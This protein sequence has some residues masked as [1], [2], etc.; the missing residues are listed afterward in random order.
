M[1]I[2]V[3]LLLGRWVADREQARGNEA[4]QVGG[5]RHNLSRLSW[6]VLAAVADLALH[7]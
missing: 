2:E 6:V 4:R 3:Q 5:N 7:G 1:R